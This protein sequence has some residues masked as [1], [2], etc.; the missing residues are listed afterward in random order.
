MSVKRNF[1]KEYG[2]DISL[3]KNGIMSLLSHVIKLVIIL[4]SSFA[5]TQHT[6]HAGII[7]NHGP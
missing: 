3:K 2:K 4:I 1:I 6:S 7:F 5:C